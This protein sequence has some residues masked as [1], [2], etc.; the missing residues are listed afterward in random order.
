MILFPHSKINLGLNVIEKR[1]DG[2]HNIETV[3]YPVKLYDVLEII[4]N[5]SFRKKDKKLYFQV[6]GIKIPNHRGANLCEKAYY[7]LDSKFDLP[8]LKMHLHKSIPIGSGLGGGSADCAF[9]LQMIC[10]LFKLKINKTQLIK[11]ASALGSDC[12]FFLETGAVFGTGK[13][14]ILKPCLVDL[15]LYNI[16]LVCPKIHVATKEAYKSIK[17]A[18]SEESLKNL[19][20]LH[21]SHWKGKIKNDFEIGVFKK[22]PELK[23]IKEHLYKKGALYSSMSGSGSSVYGVYEKKTKMNFKNCDCFWV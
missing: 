15:S 23:K 8:P 19:I 18:R 14:D 17:P 3:F 7:A 21:P 22:H 5:K 4:E 13:G 16:F 2:F 9:T 10:K 11:T 1:K 6:S 12:P 20:K